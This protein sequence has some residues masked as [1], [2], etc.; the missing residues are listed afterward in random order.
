MDTVMCHPNE[1]LLALIAGNV[2]SRW[3]SAANPLGMAGVAQSFSS[4]ATF[5]PGV[6]Q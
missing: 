6:V 1:G 4:E 2:M 3:S 5:H